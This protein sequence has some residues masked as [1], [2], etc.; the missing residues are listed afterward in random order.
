VLREQMI[1][2]A[3]QGETALGVSFLVSLA[4]S[5]STANSGVKALFDALNIIYREEEKVVF[6]SSMP[7]RCRSRLA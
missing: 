5:L 2:L 1:R 3:S 7:S 4:I 6:S